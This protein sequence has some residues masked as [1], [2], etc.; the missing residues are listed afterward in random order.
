M[1]T[2]TNTHTGNHPGPRIAKEM[3]TIVL[4]DAGRPTNTSCSFKRWNADNRVIEQK[5]NTTIPTKSNNCHASGCDTTYTPYTNTNGA[6]V[7]DTVSAIASRYS[8]T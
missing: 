1:S 8:P 4:A 3:T 7:R 5:R 6:I 2:A